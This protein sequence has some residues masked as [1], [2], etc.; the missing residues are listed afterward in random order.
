MVA[1]NKADEYL[2]KINNTLEQA[3][4]AFTT[5]MLKTVKSTNMEVHNHLA[6]STK[7]L[8]ST[9]AELEGTIVD[10]RREKRVVE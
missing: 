3:H 10:F 2:G 8:A 5:Q 6:N 7:L 1:Q 9:V 4:T